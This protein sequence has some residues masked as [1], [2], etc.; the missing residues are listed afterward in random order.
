M[1]GQLLGRQ[2]CPEPDECFAETAP[3]ENLDA[4]PV[5]P[6]CEEWGEGFRC[7]TTSFIGKLNWLFR[8]ITCAIKSLKTQTD[9]NTTRITVLENAVRLVDVFINQATNELVE[10]YSDGSTESNDLNPYLDNTD[11]DTNTQAANLTQTPGPGANQVTISWD[12][13]D[14]ANGG[15]VIGNESTII[16]VGGNVVDTNTFISAINGDTNGG[17][18][19]FNAA[20][21]LPIQRSDGQTWNVQLPPSSQML[22]NPVRILNVAQDRSAGTYDSGNVTINLNALGG[23]TVPAGA[24]AAIIRCGSSVSGQNNTGGGVASLFAYGHIEVAR[25]AAQLNGGNFFSPMA[26]VTQATYVDTNL[27]GSDNDD[28]ND[29]IVPLNGSSIA[30]RAKSRFNDT[31]GIDVGVSRISVIGFIF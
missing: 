11:T 14:V 22:A 28:T 10:V 18:V 4:P 1:L 31:F 9:N 3:T 27:I 7:D 2:I 19:G 12:V 30:Y 5:E 29:V 15:A 6:G 21:V 8:S 24:V 23:V 17:N 20:R 25:T 16:N 26:V 13:I